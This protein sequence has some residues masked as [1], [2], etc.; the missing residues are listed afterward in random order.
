MK[1]IKVG[2]IGTGFGAKVHAPVMKSHPGYEVTAISSV[3]RGRLDEIK[4]ETGIQNVYN[5][6]QDMVAKE[7]LD[8]VV[9]AS[10]PLLHHDMVLKAYEKGVHV[11]CEKPMSFNKQESEN[12][13]KA[14][15]EAG[16]LGFINFEYRFLPARQKIKEMIE[17][18]K[19]GKVLHVN[20]SLNIAGYERY[21]T[22]KRG[23]LSQKDQA[24]GM[25]GA[26]GSH[27]FDSLLWWTNA[28]INSLSGQLTTHVP[29]YIDE[30]GEKEVRTADDAFQAIGD[31]V[32][33]G[34]FSVGCSIAVRHAEGWQLEVYGTEGTLKMQ[35]DS[36]VQLGLGNELLEEV[37]LESALD[38][39]NGMNQVAAGYYNAL[40]RSIDSLY[41]ALAEN[42]IHPHLP[43]LEDGHQVQ[44][45]LDAI[46][47][48][49]EEKRTIILE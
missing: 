21:A 1:K 23:W 39:P 24:G 33:G 5:N 8:L 47:V 49:H 4:E 15:D 45:I 6:W 16:K 7:E 38:I 11:L 31:F 2:I 14:R 46:K 12:M 42:E 17:S 37:E 18:G 25:L 13:I 30:N 19:L 34:T 44:M 28:K 22:N 32:G 48:S 41:K 9:V 20:F 26:V 3:A 10:A 43:T 29:E 27:L 40:Y 36:K 35:E